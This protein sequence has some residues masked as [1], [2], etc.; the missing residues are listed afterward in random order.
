MV[1]KVKGVEYAFR[2]C[3]SDS[4]MMG[5]PESE[6]D[7][8]KDEYLNKVVLKTCKCITL[9]PYIAYVSSNRRWT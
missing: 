9:K 8:N 2:W 5:S 1:L 3:P 4:F 6:K 7:R